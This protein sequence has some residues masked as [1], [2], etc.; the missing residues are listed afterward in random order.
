MGIRGLH[1]YIYDYRRAFLRDNI[2]KLVQEFKEARSLEN[3]P[4]VVVDTPNILRPLF[5]VS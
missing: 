5:H 1:T 2:K 3:N 4:V